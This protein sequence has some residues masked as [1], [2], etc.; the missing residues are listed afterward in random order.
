MVVDRPTAAVPVFK[1][2]GVEPEWPTPDLLHCESIPERSRLHD[3]EIRPHR[4]ADLAQ[5][6]YLRRGTA[7]IEVEGLQ[8]QAV[9]PAVQVIPPLAIHG[10]RFSRDVDGYIVTL[11]APLLASLKLHLGAQQAV[12]ERAGLYP[13]SGGECRY[14]DTLFAAIASEYATPAPARDL[15]LQSLIGVLAVWLGRQLLVRDAGERERGRGRADRADAYLRDFL[16]L[17]EDHFHQHWSIETYAHRLDITPAHLNSLCRRLHGQT[18]LGVVHQR[19]LLEAKRNLIYTGLTINQ[20]AELLGFSEPAY[21]T[22]FFRRLSGSAPTAFRR[23]PTA[24]NEG[25]G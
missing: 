6:L 12:L 15:M 7:Q 10:F 16:R 13:L 24:G 21:F 9:Q 23:S 11:A 19:L 1:L 4:H 14:I 22:R 3:W 17:V 5:L 2:Y 20:I 18:A 8:R 25:A